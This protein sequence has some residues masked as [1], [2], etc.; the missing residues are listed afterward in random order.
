MSGDLK[1]LLVGPVPP[2]HGGISVHVAALEQQVRAAG[3]PCR[4]LDLFQ[5]L[6]QRGQLSLIHQR[7]QRDLGEEL[8]ACCHGARACLTAG[9]GGNLQPQGVDS[10][11]VRPR[12]H[13]RL[14]AR[15]AAV[16]R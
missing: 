12:S 10:S 8:D 3:L 15:R 16:H 1:L 11:D 6:S 7:K 2:P 5:A 14:G 9:S 4:V 13:H